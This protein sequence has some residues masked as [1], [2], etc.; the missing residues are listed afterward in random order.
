MVLA[1]VLGF[2]AAGTEELTGSAGLRLLVVGVAAALLALLRRR[3]PAPV[4]TVTGA[5]SPLLKVVGWSAGR[6]IVGAGR[7]LAAF[8]VAYG[9]FV[10]TMLVDT[11]SQQ[12]PTTLVLLS[13]L[14]FLATAVVPGLASR[15]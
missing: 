12:T 5:L 13:T 9:L 4:P 15:Y 10:G 1:L 7:A 6:R 14:Y 8:T 3:M 2:M 11:W